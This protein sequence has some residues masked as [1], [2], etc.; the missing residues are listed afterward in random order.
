MAIFSRTNT[1]FSGYVC[2]ELGIPSKS[3]LNIFSTADSQTIYQK[4]FYRVTHYLQTCKHDV[5]ITSPV[6]MNADYL[7]PE[8]HIL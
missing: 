6:A 2:E 8:K 7:I 3:K 1:K 5:R 4:I